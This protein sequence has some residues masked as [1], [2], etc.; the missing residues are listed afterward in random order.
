VV[1]ACS[2]DVEVLNQSIERGRVRRALF[3][4]DGTLSVIREGWERV[5][6]PLMVEMIA[7]EEGD[8]DGSVRREA[9][10]YVDE[11]TGLQTILQ[12]DWLAQA[13]ARRRGAGNALRAEEY[14]A[15]YHARLMRH[16]HD[17]LAG[18]AS[19]QTPRE[20]MMLAGAEAFLQAL[21]E[22]GI[23][24][25]VASGTDVE[26]VRREAAALGVARYFTGG[27]FGA[28]GASRACSKAAVIRDTLETHGLEGPELLVVGDGPVE[29][30]EGKLRGAIT[31]GVAS[32]EVRR[33]GLNP[34]K[35]ERL[36]AAGA[37]LIVPDF[38]VRDALLAR[39]FST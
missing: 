8:P 30:R 26:D 39:I 13:V 32:D 23:T 38:T 5:M 15:L 2:A 12:M 28:V 27:I 19:G 3:D 14:K 18:V 31:V 11:S 16:I 7:G 4:F 21:S 20:E 6:V 37:D 22:R 33:R 17:R 9:Q 25:Y 1:G 36:L 35:R 24:L 29:I 10:R 34:R